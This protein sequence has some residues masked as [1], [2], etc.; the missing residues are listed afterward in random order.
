MH[1]F[2]TYPGQYAFHTLD[3]IYL[4]NTTRGAMQSVTPGTE[5]TADDLKLTQKLREEIGVFVR[6]GKCPDW[7]EFPR[8]TMA[9]GHAGQATK[10]LGSY[11]VEACR[12]WEPRFFN[13]SWAG[14]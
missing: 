12:F 10:F 3:S 2:S 4:F 14:N 8:V 5:P 1:M 13:Y 11:H 9:L 7:E 6:T